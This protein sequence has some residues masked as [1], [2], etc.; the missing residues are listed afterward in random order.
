MTDIMSSAARSLRM[1]KIRQ[2]DTRPEI[3]LR[4]ALHARGF[5]YRLHPRNLPGRPDIVLPRFRVVVFVHGC[6]W[7]GHSCRAG[8]LPTSNVDYW[9][10]KI[11]ANRQRDEAKE[12]QLV[13]AGWRILTI[14]ECELGSNET[15][16][17]TVDRAIAFI[18][19]NDS[20]PGPTSTA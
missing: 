9:A 2:A 1:S 11:R 6:F 15:R 10:G 4:K 19:R 7:H 5:R 18:A 3:A 12:R 16:R 14:W 20:N 8:R 13:E 17:T